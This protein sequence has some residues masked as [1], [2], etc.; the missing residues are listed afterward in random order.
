MKWGVDL[1]TQLSKKGPNHRDEWQKKRSCTTILDEHIKNL[2]P[3]KGQLIR[4]YT[5][6][7]FWSQNQV[8]TR[9]FQS[10]S[11][12][13][14]AFCWQA[15]CSKPNLVNMLLFHDTIWHHPPPT[16]THAKPT[17]FKGSWGFTVPALAV[18]HP[19]LPLKLQSSPVYFLRLNMFKWFPWIWRYKVT[20]VSSWQIPETCPTPSTHRFQLP[21]LTCGESQQTRNFGALTSAWMRNLHMDFKQWLKTQYHRESIRVQ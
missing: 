13:N 6:M 9:D 12:R 15:I 19:N 2:T 10:A 7:L 18:G 20:S 14:M 11:A 1:S 21:T 16:Q 5:K 4:L 8:Q 17:T 3:K